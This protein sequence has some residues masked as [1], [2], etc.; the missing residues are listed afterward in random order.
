MPKKTLQTARTT[1]P[2][3]GRPR[4][5][6]DAGKPV[7]ARVD[8]A[9]A[10]LAEANDPREPSVMVRG[11]ALV[12]M[13]ERGELEALTA[14]SLRDQVSRVA[15]FEK[16]DKDG[17]PHPVDP[18]RGDA[19]VALERDSSAYSGLPTVERVVDVPVCVPGDGRPKLITERG[20]DRESGVYYLPAAG[21]EDA[22]PQELNT[23]EDL[24]WA[25]DVLLNDYLGDFAFEG[26]ESQAHALALLLLP[27][28]RDLIEGPTPLHIVLAPDYGV[29]KTLLASAALLP[30][31]G[32]VA[33]MSQTKNE[34][35]MRKRITASLIGGTSAILLDNLS[36]KLDSGALASALTSPNSEWA[37]RVL[38][39]SKE[40]V[41]PIRNAWVATGNNV[42]LAPEQ[43][44]RVVPIFLDPGEKKPADRERGD[45]RHPDLMGW[46]IE[47][48]RKLVRA[49]LTLIEHWRLGP[50]GIEGGYTFVRE[51][52]DPITGGPTL[53]SF[54]RWAGVVGGVL[55]SAR[56]PGFLTNR[57][58]VIAEANEQDH[59]AEVFLAAL[60]EA[61]DAPTK[62]AEIRPL[63]EF[64]GEL[65]DALPV[66]LVEAKNLAS[67]LPQWLKQNNRRWIGEYR[68]MHDGGG[69]GQGG[70]R[71]WSVQH[72]EPKPAG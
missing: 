50:A 63:C 38:G 3:P 25:L 55:E 46:A 11:G 24:D 27:F 43:V 37:D 29:G 8:D 61:L 22:A 17:H 40:V 52:A 66:A 65:A 12:R 32:P 54:E 70:R 51:D 49:A 5:R 28:V 9:I 71:R 47:E 60:H 13:T 16:A 56:I 48:R 33:A 57:A 42:D 2:E 18:M 41:L 69:S 53:G 7:H 10:T 67:K 4:V 45:F 62:T 20:L 44:R 58:R 30:G 64:G 59:E 39:E 6:L 72:R 26:A 15:Q 1:S 68:L 31:C 19:V 34:E 21:L 14:D 23:T 35:E 36:G